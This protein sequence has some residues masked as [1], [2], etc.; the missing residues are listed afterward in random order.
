MPNFLAAFHEMRAPD[1][2]G[3]MWVSSLYVL[4]C[5]LMA[6][7]IFPAGFMQAPLTAL[8]LISDGARLSKWYPKMPTII[9]PAADISVP[10]SGNTVT[11]DVFV[12][13]VIWTV[14]VGAGSALSPVILYNCM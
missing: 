14:I 7:G 12:D 3:K 9:C 11:G 10:E 5:R 4:P 1:T 8:E 2:P 6:T 13:D